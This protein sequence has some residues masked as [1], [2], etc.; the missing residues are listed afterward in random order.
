[1]IGIKV[2]PLKD[3]LTC[4]KERLR[5]Q[6]NPI[7]GSFQPGAIRA[8]NPDSVMDP[9]PLLIRAA[10]PVLSRPILSS[11]VFVGAPS[12]VF[13]G[14]PSPVFVRSPSPVFVGAPN[15]VLVRSPSPVLLRSPSP[16]LLRPSFLNGTILGRVPIIVPIRRNFTIVG[17]FDDIVK[18]KFTSSVNTILQKYG[19]ARYD[20]K[21]MLGNLSDKLDEFRGKYK[22]TVGILTVKNLEYVEQENKLVFR[23]LIESPKLSEMYTY[24]N[25]KIESLYINLFYLNLNDN[26][27]TLAPQIL[28]DTKAML[29][30]NGLVENTVI[31]LSKISITSSA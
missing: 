31:Q 17:N 16:V 23:L 3:I 25:N 20:L 4:L 13:V 27:K 1:M 8:S 10:S 21:I 18:Q 19:G 12:P 26:N 11:P 14:A 22:G 5:N 7:L 24:L 28:A 29:N 9:N 30:F 15:S 6:Q 2:F